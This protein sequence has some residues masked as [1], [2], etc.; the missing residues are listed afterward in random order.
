MLRECWHFMDNYDVLVCPV[1]NKPAGPHPDPQEIN[2]IAYDTFWDFVKQ[3]AGAFCMAF[4]VTGWPAV[5]VRGGTAPDGMPIGVQVVAKPWRED[6]AIA[7]AAIIEKKLGGWQ[8]PPA[9]D[10]QF[11]RVRMSTRKPLESG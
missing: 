11:F 10:H 1:G 9:L 6:Q 7:V 4:N 2:D 3:E 8:A 5:V